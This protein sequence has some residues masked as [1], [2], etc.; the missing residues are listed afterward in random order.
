MYVDH[1]NSTCARNVRH[2]SPTRT[3]RLQNEVFRSSRPRDNEQFLN[4]CSV[5]WIWRKRGWRKRGKEDNLDSLPRATVNTLRS[6]VTRPQFKT[7]CSILSRR[8]GLLRSKQ[9]RENRRATALFPSHG[10][11]AR[12]RFPARPKNSNSAR[13]LLVVSPLPRHRDD[14]RSTTIIISSNFA[15]DVHYGTVYARRRTRRSQRIMDGARRWD[16]HVEF[17]ETV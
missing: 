3:E 8:T 15:Q 16:A 7:T 17:R 10:P 5:E 14:R 11:N 9:H 12:L 6:N 2:I 13:L 1:R 4:S